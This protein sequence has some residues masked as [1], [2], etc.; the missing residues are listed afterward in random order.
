MLD[1]CYIELIFLVKL[2]HYFVVVG[3]EHSVWCIFQAAP[4]KR[5][6]AGRPSKLQ[7]QLRIYS[8]KLE[9]EVTNFLL[10]TLQVSS[11]IAIPFPFDHKINEHYHNDQQHPTGKDV[12]NVVFVVHGQSNFESFQFVS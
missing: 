4:G 6:L 2:T 3:E 11:S 8:Y 7:R 5:S 9:Y 1:R 12:R 10:L